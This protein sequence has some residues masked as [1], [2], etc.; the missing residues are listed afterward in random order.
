MPEDTICIKLEDE[1]VA[2]A[3]GP[4]GIKVANVLAAALGRGAGA[5]GYADFAW[6]ADGVLV[7]AVGVVHND[8]PTVIGTFVVS[9]SRETG[10]H[11]SIRGPGGSRFP[12]PEFYASIGEAAA[13]A[14]PAY[15]HV[16]TNMAAK[17]R[18]TLIGR[19]RRSLMSESA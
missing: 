5:Q 8:S 19:L 16:A 13:A 6:A 3:I 14:M 18:P 12:G 10:Q 9:G 15:M 1:K 4:H 17:L 2:E 7:I 11:C